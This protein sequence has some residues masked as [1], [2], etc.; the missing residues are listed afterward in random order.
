MLAIEASSIVLD[1]GEGKNRHRALDGVSLRVRAGE[2]VVIVGPSGSGKSSLLRCLNG[3]ER[4]TAGTVRL[5]GEDILASPAAL[6]GARRRTGTIFQSFNLFAMRTVLDNVALGLVVLAGTGWPDARRRAS[7]YLERV[8]VGELGARY[9]FQISGGQ[10]QRV[11]IARAL[12]LE[13]RLLLLDEPTSALD[14]ELVQGLLDLVRGIVAEG[15]LTLVCV[16]HEMGFARRLADRAVFLGGGKVLAEGDPA[17]V[18]D[19]DS[20]TGPAAQFLRAMRG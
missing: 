6:Q 2:K 10:Q 7:R 1:L 8:G 5:F 18:L 20:A 15:G 19:P 9:P 16:T 4:P 13:P 11:A 14:P 12:A 3:L 17:A